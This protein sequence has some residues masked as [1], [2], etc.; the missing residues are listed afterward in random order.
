MAIFFLTLHFLIVLFLVVGFPVGLIWNNRRFRFFHAGLLLFVTCLM[1]LQIPC[2]LTFL[3]EIYRDI[4]YEGS[5]LANWLNQIIYLRWFQPNHV[6]ILD[7]WFA[8]LVF[9][10]FFWYP[11]KKKNEKE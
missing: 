2:P 11:V 9:S 6:F 4:S 8:A 10:S 1:I 3:E 7:M 5:F